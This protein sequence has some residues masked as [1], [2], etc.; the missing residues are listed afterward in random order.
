LLEMTID[1]TG[2]YGSESL[3]VQCIRAIPSQDI[4]APINSAKACTFTSLA[5]GLTPDVLSARSKPIWRTTQRR[6]LLDEWVFARKVEAMLTPPD[7]R[8]ESQHP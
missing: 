1:G 6:D 5:G 3:Q 4:E 7:T 8:G 2:T